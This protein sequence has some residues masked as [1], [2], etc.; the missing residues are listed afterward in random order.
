MNRIVDLLQRLSCTLRS[1]ERQELVVFGSAAIFFNN[2]DLGRSV[3]D[4]DVFASGQT[5]SRLNNRFPLLHKE[6]T[7]GGEVPYLLPLEGSQI[8]ILRSFPGVEFAFV[9][10]RARKLDAA[11]GFRVAALAD[12]RSWKSAQGRPKDLEDIKAIDRHLVQNAS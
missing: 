2:V 12:L 6:S 10:E 1:A 5:F 3:G 8:E 4:L 7:E 11:E 9:F